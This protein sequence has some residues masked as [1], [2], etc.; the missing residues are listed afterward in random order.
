MKL[1]VP[2]TGVTNVQESL[3]SLKFFGEVD[4]RSKVKT[5]IDHPHVVFIVYIARSQ[6][7]LT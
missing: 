2:I 4:K 7:C 3:K 6:H 5:N 1:A